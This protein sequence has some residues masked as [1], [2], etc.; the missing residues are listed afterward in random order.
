MS[1]CLAREKIWI[2]DASSSSLFSKRI[3]YLIDLD[4][5]EASCSAMI[6]HIDQCLRWV[7]G[8]L[9]STTEA[10]TYAQ[11]CVVKI[12]CIAISAPKRRAWALTSKGSKTR[13]IAT[14]NKRSMENTPSRLNENGN[15]NFG[16]IVWSRILQVKRGIKKIIGAS[17][18]CKVAKWAAPRMV[19]VIYSS[20][21]N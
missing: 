5:R 8:D 15:S 7:C 19:E 21:W 16:L 4:Y 1:K 14:W 18:V 6:G 13:A 2:R 20:T 11:S 3:N 10:S 12:G 17:W 9:T